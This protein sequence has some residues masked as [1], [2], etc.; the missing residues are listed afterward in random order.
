MESYDEESLI[1]RALPYERIVFAF[2]K[3]IWLDMEF[4]LLDTSI[5]Q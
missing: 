5:F 4:F 3:I 2:P 1:G